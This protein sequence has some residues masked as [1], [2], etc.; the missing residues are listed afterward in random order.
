MPQI[1]NQESPKF[2]RRSTTLDREQL[3]YTL[4][5]TLTYGVIA[6]TAVGVLASVTYM[7]IQ[8]LKK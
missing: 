5:K 4:Q 2:T 8:Q 7:T 3:E 1:E 6:F